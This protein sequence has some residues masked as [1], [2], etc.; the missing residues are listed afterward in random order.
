MGG[1]LLVIAWPRTF[2]VLPFND[3]YIIIITG[4]LNDP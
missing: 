3:A 4:R 1:H 2:A